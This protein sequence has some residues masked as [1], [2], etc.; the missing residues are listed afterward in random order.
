MNSFSEQQLDRGTQVRHRSITN[1][2]ATTSR[3]I[4]I[5]VKNGRIG[6]FTALPIRLDRANMDVLEAYLDHINSDNLIA[7]HAPHLRKAMLHRTTPRKTISK[8]MHLCGG[9]DIVP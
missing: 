9:W 7:I 4:W 6:A 2:I 3:A 5:T 8:P 1:L